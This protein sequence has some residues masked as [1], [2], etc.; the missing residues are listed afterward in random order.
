MTV[1]LDELAA[2]EL[3]ERRPIAIDRLQGWEQRSAAEHDLTELAASI[4]AHPAVAAIEQR[5]FRLID[6]AE[7]RLRA[8][9]VGLLRGWTLAAAAAGARELSCDPALAPAVEIGVRAG[10]GLDFRAVPYTAPAALPGSR[11]RRAVARQLM[12]AGAGASRRQAKHARVAVVAAGKLALALASLSGGELRAACVGLMPFP[13]LDHGNGLLL[14]A[15]RRLPLLS[16]Y[17]P[18]RLGSGVPVILPARL[19]LHEDGELDRALSLLVTRVLGAVAS[20]FDQAVRSLDRIALHRSLR[21]VLLPSGAYGAARLLIEWARGRG[22]RVGVMQHGIYAFCEFDG[23][24]RR[25]D[26]ILGWGEGTEEQIARWPA[27][28]PAVRAVGV[29][30]LLA[31][32]V[33]PGRG[34]SAAA[35]VAPRKVLIATSNTVDTP[36]GP[37]AFCEMFIYA[38]APDIGRLTEA[39]VAVELRPHPIEDP[40]RY[41]R[42]LRARG[43][44]VR[45]ASA[46]S[47]PA[48]LAGVDIVISSASSVAFEAA[49]LGVPVLLWLGPAPR[50]MREEHL[51]SPWSESLPGTFQ[52]A[53]DLRPLVSDLLERPTEGLRVAR[54]LGRRLARYAQ[55][56]DRAAFAAGLRML[57]E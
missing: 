35:G 8:E 49:A 26:V 33:S 32:A 55:P 57:G 7:Y 44:D 18:M 10:L 29:P 4:A 36:I 42:L 54:E 21:A 19:E 9:L 27:P 31:A 40:E 22:L 2:E 13:G 24:D 30:G 16:S 46:G 23:S 11:R 14:A 45:I 47:F 41:R 39:G 25:A 15:R 48:A 56:F 20:E 51:L 50:W 17:E 1:V 28:R 6:F 52:T 12:R 37:A 38:L 43:L 5:G 53:E 34:G 3:T